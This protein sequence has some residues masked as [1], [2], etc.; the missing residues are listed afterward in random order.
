MGESLCEGKGREGKIKTNHK[1]V[2]CVERVRVLVV[3]GGG[4]R[5]IVMCM[6]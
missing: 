3:G 5:N 4:V 2:W 1:L 6:L